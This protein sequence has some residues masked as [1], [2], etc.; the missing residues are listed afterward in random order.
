MA[1]NGYFW[2]SSPFGS[3]NSYAGNLDVGSGTIF[4]QKGNGRVLAF[5]VRC[6]SQYLTK[7]CVCIYFCNPECDKVYIRLVIV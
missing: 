6:V 1:L 7:M 3:E 2:S 5:S 4:V